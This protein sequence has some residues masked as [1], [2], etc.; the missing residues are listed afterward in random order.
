VGWVCRLH[1]EAMNTYD[2]CNKSEHL[3]DGGVCRIILSF[4]CCFSSLH[5][6]VTFPLA[7]TVITILSCRHSSVNF[8]S[9]HTL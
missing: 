2:F 7:H 8:T 6:P 4:E 5:P 3:E 1:G 9:F